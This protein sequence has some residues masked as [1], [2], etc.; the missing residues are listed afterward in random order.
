M[1]GKKIRAQQAAASIAHQAVLG[2]ITRLEVPHPEQTELRA[3]VE[4]ALMDIRWGR[5]IAG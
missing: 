2:I 1:G 5:A 3:K 4:A